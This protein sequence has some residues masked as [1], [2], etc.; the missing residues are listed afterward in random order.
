MKSFTKVTETTYTPTWIKSHFITYDEHFI[1][2][3]QNFPY[4]CDRC[5]KC[6]HKF[7]LG[8]SIGLA[9]FENI[10]NRVLCESCVI[11]LECSHQ[12]A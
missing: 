1:R 5:E 6:D 8:E 10:G 2:I 12:P 9:A 4:K 3:R 7:L 11:E